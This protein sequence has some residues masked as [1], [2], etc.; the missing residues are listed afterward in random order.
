MD[1][2]ALMLS[3]IQFAFTVSFH[4]IFPAFTVGLAAW[5]A[6]LQAR[7]MISGEPV[8][9]RL[10]DFWLKI[11]AVA[12]GLGVVSGIV[13]AFQFGTNWSELARRTGP[14][15]GPLLGCES[16][17]AFALEASFFGVLMFGRR[18]VPRWFYLF[19]CLMVCLGTSLSSFWILVNNS[20]MQYPTG[21]ALRPDGVFVPT[22]WWAIIFNGVVWVRFPHM[23]LA[24]YVTTSFCVA[25]TGAWSMLRG[26]DRAEARAMVR[27][28][29]GLAAVLVPLQL[30]F[31]HLTGDY[32]VK[33]QPS[34]IAAI[35]GHW[36]SRAPAGEILFAWP[37]EAQE[38]NHFVIALPAPAGSLID[39]GTLTGK[40]IGIKD[41]PK[42][43][44]PPVL[45]PFFA[46]RIM[47]GCGLL[48]LALAWGGIAFYATGRLERA[49]WLQ[50]AIFLSFP[51]GFVATLTGWFTAEV[52]RQPWTVYG[53]LRTA[54]A[55]TPFLTSPQVATSLA[56]FGAVYALIFAAGT[57]YIY[58]M[59]RAGIL[60]TPA[61]VGSA[62]NP[63]RPLAVPGNSPG[64]PSSN[65]A[66]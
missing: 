19:A 31:G 46:F 33:H 47:V 6:F 54:D 16:F 63:K 30:F 7:A 10:F 23:V 24:A 36:E 57:V 50:W 26:R 35:E 38:K 60:P 13:M 61:H 44:R 29:L 20:W 28:G 51:L 32:V 66:E 40:V 58:R 65:P 41:I 48:M 64:T 62:A 18:R 59:L 15:Q 14:I 12:F 53:Q 17:T 34:K 3:R 39:D 2:S 1:I 22:D 43:D 5:L 21:F 42:A 11:F 25:A 27:M 55:A 56:V 45:I 9:D 49:R 37:D 8:Y 52:G 4:I